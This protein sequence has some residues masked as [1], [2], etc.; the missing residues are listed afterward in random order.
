M[1]HIFTSWNNTLKVNAERTASKQFQMTSRNLFVYYKRSCHLDYEQH[2]ASAQMSNNNL[3]STSL[4]ATVLNAREN[5]LHARRPPHRA[6]WYFVSKVSFNFN[7]GSNTDSTQIIW[8]HQKQRNMHIWIQSTYCPR[9]CTRALILL[10]GL[11][12][13]CEQRYSL[14]FSSD[15][16]F[17]LAFLGLYI[18]MNSVMCIW[19]QLQHDIYICCRNVLLA[20][21]DFCT[22]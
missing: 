14:D 7:V 2:V 11:Y 19:A 15:I 17:S 5:N 16:T 3:L 9:P 21:I 6:T 18:K 12:V 4:H 20:N 13:N 8:S 22:L 10:H 1:K